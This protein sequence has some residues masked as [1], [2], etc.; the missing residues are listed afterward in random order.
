MYAIDITAYA[1]SD[2]SNKGICKEWA[3]CRCYGIDRHI[4]DHSTYTEASDIELD[5]GMDFSVKSPKGTLMSGKF[6]TTCK[7]FEGIWRKYRRTCHSNTFVFVTHEWIAYHMDI[8]EFSKFVHQF[9]YLKRDSEKNGGNMKIAFYEESKRMRNW[10]AAN[11][12]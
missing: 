9:G 8:N 10:L 11:A 3:L 2:N 5:N 7:T 6:C 12:R 1:N 4:H